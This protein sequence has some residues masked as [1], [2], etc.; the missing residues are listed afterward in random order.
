MII[1]NNDPNLEFYDLDINGY[2][3]Y[4][5]N[6]VPLTGVITAYFEN[7]IYSTLIET[8]SS[9]VNGMRLGLQTLYWNNGQMR[10]QYTI[11]DGGLDGLVR[12]WDKQGN[13]TYS[14]VYTKG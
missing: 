9:Y 1:I 11:G 6:G 13:L 10:S 5:Y 8:E 12:E 2:P 14:R 3:K 7:P 4:E